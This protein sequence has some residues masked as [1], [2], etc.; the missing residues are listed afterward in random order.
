MVDTPP[1]RSPTE[2]AK[3]R[4]QEALIPALVSQFTISEERKR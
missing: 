4:T 2:G 3:Y 1:R